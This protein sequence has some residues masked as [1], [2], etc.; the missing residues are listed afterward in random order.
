MSLE[1]TLEPLWQ[2]LASH[3]GNSDA[4]VKNVYKRLTYEYLDEDRIYHNLT[5][6]AQ[7]L[8]TAE[9]Y[10]ARIKAYDTVRLAIWFHDVIYNP[11]STQNEERSAIFA[12]EQLTKLGVGAEIVEQ[13]VGLILATS[14]HTEINCDPSS[15]LAYFL[16]FDLQILGRPLPV[17][18]QYVQYIR[19]EYK[20][21]PDIMYKPGR[22]KVLKR[23]LEAVP[24]YKTKEF[25][26]LY[27]QQAKANLA[28][29][30]QT[31]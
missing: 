19:K 14:N 21:V 16:D 1:K 27:E 9:E 13:V 12:E 18:Q 28:W 11:L 20:F 3:Y 22:R 8:K 6:I 4:V 7:L 17:Y 24:L 15:D 30:L 5:H 2:A 31:L 25:Q 10:Q 23:F 26:T 29:E